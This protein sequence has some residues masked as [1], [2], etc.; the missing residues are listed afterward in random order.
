MSYADKTNGYQSAVEYVSDDEF[1]AKN[2]LNLTEI[3]AFGCTSRGQAHR[4]GRW[5][6]ETEAGKET[7][8][9]TV[10]R[11]GLMHLPGDIIRVN[12]N[13]YAGTNIGGRVLAVNGSN[14]T[15]DREIELSGNSFLTYINNSAKENTIRIT[16]VNGNTVTLAS[17]PVDLG[18]YSVWALTTETVKSGLYKAISLTENED[19]TFTITALQHEPQKEAIVDKRHILCQPLK[20]LIVLHK[21]MMW[22]QKPV[23]T[24]NYMSPWM[25]ALVMVK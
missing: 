2:G 10:G 23:M 20:R 3:T 4:T 17:S 14:V 8:T 7:I 16:A 18:A 11:E 6:I 19:G 24:A 5:L 21:L 1:I 13:D 15:L 12:D 9:F 22:A 25:L